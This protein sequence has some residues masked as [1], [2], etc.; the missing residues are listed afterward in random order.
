[1]V[2]EMMR[3]ISETTQYMKEFRAQMAALKEQ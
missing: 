1:M 2:R 3:Q